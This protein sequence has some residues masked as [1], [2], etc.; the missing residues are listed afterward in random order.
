MNDQT[1]HHLLFMKLLWFQ[2][3]NL[4]GQP[5]NNISKN[6]RHEASTS[7]TSES[8]TR[9]ILTSLLNLT[10]RSS[11]SR[12]LFSFNP[13]LSVPAAGRS[14]RTISGWGSASWSR[15]IVHIMRFA[16]PVRTYK[17]KES[18]PTCHQGTLI[19]RSLVS[20]PSKMVD[21]ASE[22]ILAGTR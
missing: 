5:S 14:K 9:W 8:S 4:Y 7:P 10:I 19:Q 2:L 16:K 21:T 15:Y 22:P 13:W 17:S 20:D 6:N 12:N 18:N 1:M 11:E 3:L